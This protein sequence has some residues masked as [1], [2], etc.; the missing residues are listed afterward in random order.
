MQIIISC[1]CLFLSDW[2]LDLYHCSCRKMPGIA[3][4]V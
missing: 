2:S 1:K 4:W 3:D